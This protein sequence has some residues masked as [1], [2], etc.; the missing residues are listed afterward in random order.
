MKKA[1]AILG[2]IAAVIAFLTIL[3]YFGF[4]GINSRPVK[5]SEKRLFLSLS[6]FNPDYVSRFS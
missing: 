5:E 4:R 6:H 2:A 1:L 3:L